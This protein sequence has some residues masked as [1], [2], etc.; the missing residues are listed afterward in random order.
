MALAATGCGDSHE[1]DS[2]MTDASGDAA[3]DADVCM[4][5]VDTEYCCELHGGSWTEGF[6]CAVPGP[7][8]PP[9]MTN[10]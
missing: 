7:F 8:V 4:G 2:G 3:P 6:G 9:A 1:P 5:G 10:A